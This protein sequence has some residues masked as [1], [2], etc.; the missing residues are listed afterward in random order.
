MKIQRYGREAL[1][2]KTD[3]ALEQGQTDLWC[4]RWDETE[5]W[6]YENFE[7]LSAAEKARFAQYAD[8][9]SRMQ[10]LGGRVLAKRLAARYL[11][12]EEEP[13]AICTEKWGKPYFS[14]QGRKASL[15]FGLSHSGS[16]IALAFSRTRV[17]VDIEQVKY[18]EGYEAL[19]RNFFTE[20][21]WKRIAS[22][23]DIRSFYYYWTRKEAYVK[24]L[25][26]GLR[27][28]LNAFDVTGRRIQETKCE[29][30]KWKAESFAWQKYL[31]SVVYQED[32]E[33]EH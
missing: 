8:R 25:G 16:C 20:E 9:C 30:E 29:N 18:F 11:G 26:T 27:K 14:V 28:E 24:A 15:E 5:A 6:L 3:Y 33:N 7:L 23:G 19:A 2:A 12:G 21:E 22:A 4:V 1:R 17:G 31:V 13:V 10:Y 32:E